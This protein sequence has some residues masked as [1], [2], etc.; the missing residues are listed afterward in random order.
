MSDGASPSTSLES[1]NMPP[2]SNYKVKLG[3]ADSGPLG[4]QSDGPGRNTKPLSKPNNYPQPGRYSNLA[5]TGQRKYLDSSRSASLTWS[6]LI[7]DMR[8]SVERY[9]QAINTRDRADYVRRAEDISDHLRLLLAAG[10]GTTDNHSGFPSIIATNKALYPHFRD[11]M[12]RFSK[13]VLSSHI[14][15]ADFAAPDSCA[16]C[17]QEAE[18]VLNGVYGFVEVAR[19]QRGE[20]ISRLF[21]G[22]VKDNQTGGSWQ[23]N[24]LSN[25]GALSP[26]SFIDQD[27]YEPPVEPNVPLDT[28][29]MERM[30]DLKRLIVSGLR[31]LEERL[32]IQDRIISIHKH[33]R[34]SSEI[35]NQCSKVMDLYRPWITAMESVDLSGTGL[36]M[37]SAQFGEFSLQKQRVYISFAELIM[38]CQAVSAPLAD[39]WESNRGD[40]LEDR[41]D[42]V[43]AI[44]RSLESATSKV[45]YTLQNFLNSLPTSPAPNP[46]RYDPGVRS[47]SLPGQQ[48]PMSPG[49]KSMKSPPDSMGSPG[50]PESSDAAGLLSNAGNAKINKIFGE[51]PLVR[52]TTHTSAKLEDM[53]E[54]L[55][56]DFEA[57]VQYDTKTEPASIKAG[58]LTGLVEQLTRHDRYDAP[59]MLTFLLTYQSFTTAAELFE[60]LIR[61][62]S[63]HP[64]PGLSSQDVDVWVN[65]KQHPIRM[66]IVNVMKS[67]ID[68]YWMEA[69][70]ST[71]LDL[72]TRIYNFAKDT[73]ASSGIPGWRLLLNV[74]EQRM[75]GEDNTSKKLVPT[76]NFQA[77]LPILPKN[78]KK[79]RFFDIDPTELARQLTIIESRLYGKI[80]PHECLNKIWQKKTQP[81]DQEPA[82]NVKALIL[83]SNRLTNWVAEMILQHAE[84]RKRVNVIKHFVAVAE[85]SQDFARWK[86]LIREANSN[87]RRNAAR[88]ITS[89]RSPP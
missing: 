40:T 33:R 21:P 46:Q 20:E 31:R 27:D 34:L 2:N 58:T 86:N 39:E 64:P 57:E 30:N 84:P 80:K 12:S 56:L 47:S 59:F 61:R 25:L 78:M 54:Y 69:N 4:L 82:A 1:L 42:R 83:H 74:I 23:N 26:T 81:T 75:R 15:A 44:S 48:Q 63:I 41:I 3:S 17:L 8:S 37:Q 67:W 89:R 65:K 43:R 36:N 24:G 68:A 6:R 10:S 14:A 71:G 77:P 87:S 51:A 60:A 53:P 7:Q 22:F 16:K 18:G 73:V 35:C 79:L 45:N 28:G 66:R 88:S 5:G 13:L 19:S 62:W 55:R 76:P 32:V 72:V 50:T 70:D 52:E 11:M 29:M 49:R 85:V 9:R 38:A